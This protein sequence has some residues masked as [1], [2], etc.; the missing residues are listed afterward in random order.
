MDPY[1]V[2]CNR[3]DRL[4]KI[5]EKE[6]G[7]EEEGRTCKPGGGE[8]RCEISYLVKYGAVFMESLQ[9]WLLIQDQPVFHQAALIRVSGLPKQRINK[10][11]HK[12]KRKDERKMYWG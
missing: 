8:E 10:I 11:K 1:V 9:L 3:V 2:V 7:L 12:Y 6:L 5:Q 4:Q